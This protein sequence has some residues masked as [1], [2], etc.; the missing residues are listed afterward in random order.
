MHAAPEEPDRAREALGHYNRAMEELK[1]GDWSRIGA[2]L[3]KL[4]TV[5]ESL[6]RPRNDR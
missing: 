6:S 4:R 3:D 1:A 5:I 2:E